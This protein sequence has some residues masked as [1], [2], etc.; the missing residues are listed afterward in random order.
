[1]NSPEFLNAGVT[2]TICCVLASAKNAANSKLEL[3]GA[4]AAPV[5]P[6]TAMEVVTQPLYLL[7]KFVAAVPADLDHTTSIS[8]GGRFGSNSCCADGTTGQPSSAG[9]GA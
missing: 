3:G 5:G 9:G 8:M 2:P 7:M 1:M 6:L 4:P